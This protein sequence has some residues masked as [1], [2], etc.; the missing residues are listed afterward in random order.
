MRIVLPPL[1]IGAELKQY[2]SLVSAHRP[3]LVGVGAAP[4]WGPLGGRNQGLG[5]WPEARMGT[6]G[7]KARRL[8]AKVGQESELCLAPH[9]SHWAWQRV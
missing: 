8:A 4:T 1:R 7:Q 9:S 6:V 3:P 5:S 2:R